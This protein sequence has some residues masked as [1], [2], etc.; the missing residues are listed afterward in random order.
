M[1]P[2]ISDA[3]VKAALAAIESETATLAEK[4]EMLIEMAA[5]LQK[6]PKNSQ[7]L[8][9]AVLLYRRGLE[10]AT[11]D[12]PLLKA[13]CLSGM[14]TALRTIPSEGAELL[15]EAKT[16]YETALP[17]L[18]EHASPEEIGETQMNLG[19]VLQGLV[20][21]RQATMQ[22]AIQAYQK[23][24]KVFT[25]ES[26]P[27][28]FAILQNNIA[29]AYLSLPLSPDQEKMRQ[30]MAVQSFEAALKWVTLIDHPSEYAMLQN[31]LANALQ[32]LNTTHPIDNN[33]KALAAYD[34]ALKV[35]SRQDTPM[36]YANTIANKANVLFNLPDDVEH[37]EAG[38]PN[39]LKQSQ[40]YYQEAKQ[41]FGDYG[42]WERV[43]IVTEMLQDIDR[44]IAA[45]SQ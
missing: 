37:P 18:E 28:E 43:N 16:A 5:G 40:A 14:G 20:N 9:D 6:K 33:L 36:E 13:R 21:F 29:I 25:G 32:Y 24:A 27:Q 31:N 34:E 41:I 11:P 3:N 4:V 35:R 30:G 45:F 15:L 44:E 1:T 7:Q 39:N 17:I 23:A 22:E 19:V 38:N 12:L 2:T 26:Y 10:L 42:Q 8:E